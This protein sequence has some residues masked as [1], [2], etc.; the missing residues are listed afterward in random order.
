MNL[1]SIKMMRLLKLLIAHI[2]FLLLLS[3]TPSPPYEVRSPCVSSEI[4]AI[5]NI[6]PCVRRP[7]GQDIS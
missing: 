6:N 5:S 1:A 2:G 3:C 4:D 7:V